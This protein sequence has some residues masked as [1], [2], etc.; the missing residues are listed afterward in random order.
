MRWGKSAASVR[1]YGPAMTCLAALVFTSVAPVAAQDLGGNV[2]SGEP[3]MAQVSATRTFDIAAQPLGAA[4]V[5]FSEATGIQLFLDASVARGISSPGVSGTMAPEEAL[6]RL[7]AGTGLVYRFANSTTVTVERPGAK[8]APGVLQLD[9]VQ[10]QGNPVPPQ[11]LIDNLPPPYAGGQVATGGQLGL[12]GN[13]DVMDTPFNQTSYTAQKAQDQQAKTVR[14]VLIDNPSVRSAWPDGSPGADATI[15]RGFLVVPTN[16]TYGGLYGVLPGNSIMAELAERIELLNG[17]SAMLNGMAPNAN[18]IGGT[19][20]VV[21]KH[22][23]DEPLTQVTAGYNSTAQ[24]GGHADIG[25][26][27]GSDK[28]FGV[29]FN[30]VFRAGETSI[31]RNTDERALALLG[32]D[33]RGERVR[34]SADFGYQ[35][36]YVGGVVPYVTLAAAT[37]PMIGPSK[38][39]SNFGQPW[40][41]SER[42]DL[43]GV[44]RGELDLTEGVTAYVAFGGRS[45]QLTTLV[46]GTTIAVADFNGNGTA[47]TSINGNYDSYRT[48][49]AG[50][51]ALADTGP[52]GH[53]FNFSAS[54]VDQESGSVFN[55]VG[56]PYATNIYNPVFTPRPSVANPAV[57]KT[58]SFSLSNLALADTLSAADKRVQ[59]TV[60]GRFQRVASANFSA[61]TGLQTSSYDQS[62]FT[63]AAALVFKPWRNVSFY[64]NFIQALQPGTIVGPTFTNA[65]EI[66]APYKSTQFET[67]VKVDWGRLTTTMSV[68]QISQP[69]TVVDT[70][71]N[72]LNLAGEQRNRGLEINVFGEPMEGVRLLGGVMFLD[73]VLTKTQGG[74]TDGWKAPAAPDVQLNLAGEWDTPFARGMTLSGRVI[75]TSSQYL[76]V[77]S[78]RRSRPDWARFDLGVRY[79]FDNVGSPTGQPIAVRFNV[80]NVLDT[81]YWATTNSGLLVLGAPR[82]FR[83]STTVNF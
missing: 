37:L 65:G 58:L 17:P 19:I 2:P 6:R 80:D 5:R 9:P 56:T 57:N 14:D 18:S 68:F 20:N 32:L 70:A 62:A 1:G 53:A 12:L 47:T 72:T 26:R 15:I 69:S 52:I 49:E 41:Y 71:T 35:Y 24:F 82:T 73:A 55:S 78:P 76:D 38:A 46:G 67:G 59:L 42:K 81:N 36:Q 23:P 61:V 43:F 63:P 45:S 10:V 33:F 60:G 4:L 64:G 74:L 21:A 40:N 8:A 77:L 29:R 44:F 54:T 16:T 48:G 75:Y 30:G 34:F 50:L 11:A 25:R 28:Q 66:F 7:L 79:T 51:R 22:A 31:A 83:L 3:S 13:R 27:F 39:S